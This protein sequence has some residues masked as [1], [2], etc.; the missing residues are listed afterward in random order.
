MKKQD[1]MH[2]YRG[3]CL[4]RGI[5][6]VLPSLSYIVGIDPSENHHQVS[7]LLNA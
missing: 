3:L 7:P 6:P 5:I 2:S 4:S 1:V